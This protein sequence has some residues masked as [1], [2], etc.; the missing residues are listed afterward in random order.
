MAGITVSVKLDLKEIHVRC[1]CSLNFYHQPNF[2]DRGCTDIDECQAFRAGSA[3]FTY[4][5][6]TFLNLPGDE[7]TSS[8]YQP[9]P[10]PPADSCVNLSYKDGLGFKCVPLDQTYAAVMIGGLHWNKEADVL[11]ADLGR[12]DGAIPPLPA[13]V[14]HHRVSEL[15]DVCFCNQYM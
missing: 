7:W 11:K 5:Y 15:N 9:E 1:F 14:Y 2:S 12:C 4:L 8:F 10:C 6:P 13:N 3:N